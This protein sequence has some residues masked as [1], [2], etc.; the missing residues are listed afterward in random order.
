MVVVV[1]S[2]MQ[3]RVPPKYK[4]RALPMHQLLWLKDIKGLILFISIYDVQTNQDSSVD[5]AMCWGLDGQG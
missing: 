2:V 1:P 3:N 5:L 4:L